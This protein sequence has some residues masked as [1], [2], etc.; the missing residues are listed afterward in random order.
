[1]Q[2]ELP[3]LGT[4]KHL[5]VKDDVSQFFRLTADIPPPGALL[6][7]GSEGRAKSCATDAREFEM[8]Q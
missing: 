3:I 8:I 6:P 2:Q 5:V 1:M 7:K 4:S